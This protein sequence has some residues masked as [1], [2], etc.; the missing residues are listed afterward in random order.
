MVRSDRLTPK[1]WIS[2]YKKRLE[3]KAISMF[4]IKKGDEV[5]GAIIVRVSD[6]KGASK[7]YTQSYDYEG[8]RLWVE[9]ANGL[10]HEIEELINEQKNIDPDVWILERLEV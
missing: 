1:F 6:L 9:I 10:D 2:A 4:V 5:S 7:I 3:A 8:N